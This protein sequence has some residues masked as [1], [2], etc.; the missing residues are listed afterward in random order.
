MINPKWFQAMQKEFNS[1]QA[2]KTWIMFQPSV[3]V[4]VIGNISIFKI[5]YSSDGSIFRYMARVVVKGFSQ[6]Q[7][8]DSNEKFIS[9]V[10]SLT[11]K[12]VLSI[13]IMQIS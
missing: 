13:V 1:L 12:I 9:I 2:K 11:I 6:T 4:K 8:V 5:N 3:L 10:K 7:E